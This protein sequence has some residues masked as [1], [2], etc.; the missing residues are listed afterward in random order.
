VQ[1]ITERFKKG[2]SLL[3]INEETKQETVD[4]VQRLI[5][6]ESSNPPG[7]ENRIA[8]FIKAYLSQKGINVTQLPL[9]A[10]RS[11]LVARI[12]GKQP[13]SIV[14]CGHMDTVNAH[15]EKWTVPPF[16]G[17]IEED[18]IWGRGSADMKS[19]VAVILE[20]AKLI[21][22]NKFTPRKDLALVFTADEEQAYRGA[23]SVVQS[24]LIDD[25]EFLI[26]TEPTAGIAF[27]GHKGELWSE[28]TFSG[29]AAHGSV[30]ELGINSILPA[31]WF[32][33]QL[34]E[35]AKRFKIIPSRGQ[36]T[37]NIGQINGGWQV[38]TVPDTTR[39]T[40]D[41]RV[42][43]ESDKAQVLD[44]VQKLGTEA[45]LQVGAQFSMK[46]MSDNPP[47]ISNLDHPHVRDFLDA[48][49]RPA[50]SSAE[51]TLAPYYT[52]AG[53][54]VPALNIPV[55]IYGPGDISQAHQPD[56]YLA[57][58]SLYEALD[59]LARFLDPENQQEVG[60]TVERESRDRTQVPLSPNEQ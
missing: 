57:L 42:V 39:V 52:D 30:P 44:L 11:S 40:L 22:Q 48:V 60:L 20:L 15:E 46:I 26:I 34:A 47:I 28:V 2:A 50:G 37:L 41:F 53:A 54:I 21:T 23:R 38:N 9:E 7:N 16:A 10:G 25:A 29:K 14:L 35:A 8:A 58:D 27:P 19:G 4:L 45:A 18:R 51:L 24:G 32:C 12:P 36:T 59:V 56:E 49:N 31:S 55:V 5:Q 17:Q 1:S 43:S 13:G 6:I 33:L 3:R